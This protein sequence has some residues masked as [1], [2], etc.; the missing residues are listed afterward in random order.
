ME[1]MF[2]HLE[3]QLKWTIVNEVIGWNVTNTTTQGFISKLQGAMEIKVK[4]TM[5][6]VGIFVASGAEAP[7]GAHQY[8]LWDLK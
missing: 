6:N 1:A 3:W 8:M 4:C 2:I 5:G 7:P